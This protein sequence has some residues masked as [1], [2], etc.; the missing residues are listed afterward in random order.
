MTKVFISSTGKDLADYREAAIEICNRIGFSPVAME[1]FEAMSA[2]ATEGSKRK[3]EQADLYV[4]IFA[5]RYGYIEQGYDK[6]VTELEFDYADECGLDRLCFLIRPDYPWPP[7]LI[8]YENRDKLTAFK[9]RINKLIRADFTTLDSFKT[10]LIQALSAWKEQH[11]AKSELTQLSALSQGIKLAP[12]RPALVVGREEEI[13]EIKARLGALPGTQK[14]A[15]T[16][17]RGWPGV[18]KTTLVN[19]IA[20]E[21]DVIAIFSDG[22]L[23]TALGEKASVISELGAWGRQ[24]GIPD[25]GRAAT[26]SEAI[27]RLRTILQ[28]KCM[29]LIVDDVWQ[30]DDAIPF[31]QIAG[32][33]C[34]LLITTRMRDI[35]YNLANLPEEDIFV[36]GVLPD[37]KALDLLRCLTPRVVQQYPN[38]TL[39][40]VHDLEGLPLA[41]RVAGR[42][43]EAEAT[44]GVD[45]RP[46]M[47]E[48]RESHRLLEQRAPDDRFDPQTGTTPT[49]DL[50]LKNSTDRLDE[51]TRERFAMLGVFAPKPATFD[52]EAMKHVWEVEDPMP[53]LHKLVDRGL[54]EPIVSLGRFQMHAVLVMHA[55]SLLEE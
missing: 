23:W 31:K 39:A 5:H 7:D 47:E 3:L 4:G 41:L 46:L 8:D 25:V 33:K 55:Q 45:V 34:A 35:A 2:G 43:L 28:S 20:Y 42:L 11:L 22:I 38:L 49:I 10:V 1:F 50:L 48:L 18:G 19:S 32:P 30:V 37:E 29:L 36:L 6:A 16:I 24:L 13:N 17:I 53:T 52:Q 26:L 40:L 9:E 54:L 15:L 12:L 14:R 27:A 44:L 21:Q 51:E